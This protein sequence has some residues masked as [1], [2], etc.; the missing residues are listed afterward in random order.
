MSD[1]LTAEIERL[2]AENA[3]LTKDLA[4]A[5]D[6]LKVVRAEARDRRH[7]NKTLA[8]QLA[9]L[10]TDR[11]GWKA[12]AETDPAEWQEKLDAAHGTVRAMK[13]ERA[14]EKVAKGLKVTDPAKFADLLKLAGH[15]PEGNEPDEVKIAET[16]QDALKGRPWLVDAESP[17]PAPGG[18]TNAP[19]GAIGATT[20]TKPAVPGPGSDR[21][22]SVSSTTSQPASR[23]SGRL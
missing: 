20:E 2:R 7:E 10:A 14:Y 11:D 15:T 1:E 21:G 13:H 8:Q 12:K 4:G 6:D 18:A 23:V 19:G 9:E 22:Q 5:H 16:F 17:K 3:R